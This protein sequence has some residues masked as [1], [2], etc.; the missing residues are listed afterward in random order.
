MD[1]DEKNPVGR[2]SDYTKELADE[3][4]TTIATSTKGLRRLCAENPHW[5]APT[6]IRKWCFRIKEFRDLYAQAMSY[7]AGW[8]AE[9]IEDIADDGS[10]DYY[11]DKDGNERFDSEHVQR[12]RLRVDTRK[13][14]ACKLLPRVYGERVQVESDNGDA[15]ELAKIRELIA[16]CLPK[17]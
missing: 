9:E 17:E 15:S 12:S 5:P 1:D 10:N 7:R 11:E 4:C 8:L 14:I 3:I 6:N 16:K 2:P 13:W